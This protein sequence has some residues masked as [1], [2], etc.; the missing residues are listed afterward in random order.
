M[1]MEASFDIAEYF[2]SSKEEPTGVQMIEIAEK[3]A[4]HFP[5]SFSKEKKGEMLRISIELARNIMSKTR[6]INIPESDVEE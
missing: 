6:I 1:M 2:V 3:A 4:S 5:D